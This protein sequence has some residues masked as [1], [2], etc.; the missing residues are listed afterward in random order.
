MDWI[1]IITEPMCDQRAVCETRTYSMQ[2]VCSGDKY[3]CCTHTALISIYLIFPTFVVI[4]QHKY[5]KCFVYS[6]NKTIT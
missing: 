2:T 5:F 6:V 3:N 4:F 1:H